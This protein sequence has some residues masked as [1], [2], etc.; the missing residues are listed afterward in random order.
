MKQFSTL[1]KFMFCVV[2]VLL[3]ITVVL[4]VAT[5]VKESGDKKESGTNVSVTP[6]VTPS[7]APVEPTEAPEPDATETPMPT[8]SP[9]PKHK[10]AIDPGQQKSQMTEVEPIGPGATATTAK[11][12]YGATSVTT[13]KKE[14]LWTL[15]ISYKIK[16]ELENR[17]YEVVLTREEHEVSISNAERA[18]FANESGA[19]IYI[20]IQAD[21]AS[22]NTASGI[23]SQIPSKSNP[24][25][26][27]L[28]SECKSLASEIQTRLIA[29]TG[30]RDRGLRE[31]D[32]VAA[33]NWSEIPVTVLQLGFM[34]NP[35]EDAN[36][37]NEEY[38]DKL[39]KAICDGIDA[40]FGE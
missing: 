40:Y 8:P 17:G 30:T 38:Q 15:P 29:E 23:Y 32:T 22:S 4:G 33:I 34:S 16:E 25:I 35:E 7:S 14:Y 19:E 28:Y 24:Y 18:Q 36:L 6:I 3:V 21:A 10:I 1:A 31:T 13:G 2:T 26:S 27:D 11:M 20:S 9:T 39:V 37:W 12:S 5:A